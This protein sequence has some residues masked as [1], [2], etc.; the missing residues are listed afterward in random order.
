M[1]TQS[2]AQDVTVAAAA[3]LQPVVD[4]LKFI[5]EKSNNS[6]INITIGASGKLSSQINNGNAP[7]DIFMSADI[8]STSA[9]FRRGFT[10]GPPK[11]YA[12]G[13]LVLWTLADIDLSRGVAMLE[14]PAVQKIAI[15][16]AGSSPYGRQAAVVL[17]FYKIYP[18]IEKKLVYVEN[19]VEVNKLVVSKAVDIGFTSKSIVLSEAMKDKGK[20]VDIDHKSY[21]PIA[22]SGILLTKAK[23]NQD[24]RKFFNFLFSDQAKSVFRK[25]G[26]TTP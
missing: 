17:K 20:W 7:F 10:I 8:D 19:V 22:Q 1:N 2:L 11:V 9:L 25:Y 16:D 24:A 23:G 13:R 12:Y 5:F 6:R 18:D 21:K 14:D 26:Y 4:E 3:S 15:G